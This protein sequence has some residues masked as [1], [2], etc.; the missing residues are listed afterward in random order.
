[1]RSKSNVR[2]AEITATVHRKDG[3]TEER[4][5]YYHHDPAERERYAQEHPDARVEAGVEEG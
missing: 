3:T 2:E 4:R 5:S 1:M